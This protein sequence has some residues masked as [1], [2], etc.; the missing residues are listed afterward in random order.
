MSQLVINNTSTI[1]IIDQQNK[2]IMDVK[3][4][5]NAVLERLLKEIDFEKRSNINAYNRTHNR[6]NRGR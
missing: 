3:D 1:N 5:D 4:V 2:V 6:H